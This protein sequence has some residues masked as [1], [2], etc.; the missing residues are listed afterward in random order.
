MNRA[1]QTTYN[2]DPG[3]NKQSLI[4]NLTE[5]KAPKEEQFFS[6]FVT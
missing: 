1:R 6:P 3:G 5:I 4:P 2:N